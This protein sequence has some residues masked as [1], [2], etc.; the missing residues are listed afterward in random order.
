MPTTTII[1]NYQ[2]CPKCNNEIV[3]VITKQSLHACCYCP[4]CF[5]IWTDWQQNHIDKLEAL[6]HGWRSYA[7]KDEKYIDDIQEYFDTEL[8]KLTKEK[9]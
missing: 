4:A 8:L 6:L 5:E 2:K 9:L 7:W 1:T 3:N